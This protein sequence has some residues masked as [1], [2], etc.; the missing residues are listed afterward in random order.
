MADLMHIARFSHFAKYTL[1]KLCVTRASWDR[2]IFGFVGN[3]SVG[4]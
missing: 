1:L 3:L 4:G 2:L